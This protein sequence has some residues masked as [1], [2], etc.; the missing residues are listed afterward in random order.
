M[1]L[2]VTGTAVFL[3]WNVWNGNFPNSILFPK[4]DCRFSMEQH[5]KSHQ[6]QKGWKLKRRGAVR[7]F[8]M[9]WISS[10]RLESDWTTKSH[11]A[12][13]LCQDSVDIH[14][15]L[16]SSTRILRRVSDVFLFLN[17]N[18]GHGWSLTSSLFLITPKW[19]KIHYQSHVPDFWAPV[20]LTD[21]P[22][23]ADVV[24]EVWFV[25]RGNTGTLQGGGLDKGV[26]WRMAKVDLLVCDFGVGAFDVFV[27]TGMKCCKFK[28][29]VV[30][31]LT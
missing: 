5:W 16:S 9:A 28:C 10:R 18:K 27:S 20:F 21:R 19:E 22:N 15:S 2:V 31:W 8:A 17:R 12:R 13:R 29:W 4:L 6:Q 7:C 30:L 23:E 11:G 14:R 26:E 25:L 3:G 1:D 24:P